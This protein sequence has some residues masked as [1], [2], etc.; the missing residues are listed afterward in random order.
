MYIY[1]FAFVKSK[2]YLAITRMDLRIY[3]D[4]YFSGKSVYEWFE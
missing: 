2:L 3:I 1:V 4:I